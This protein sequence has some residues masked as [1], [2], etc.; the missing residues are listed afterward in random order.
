[1]RILFLITD[2][3]KG[4][5]ERYLI[6]LCSELRKYNDVE[7][8]IGSLYSGNQ[9]EDYTRDFKIVSLEY[10][11]FSFFRKN[12][13]VK[14]KELLD[15]FKP[16]VVHTHRF[17][18][19]FLSSYY[20]DRNIKYICHGHD[21]MEQLDNF[22]LS[23]LF[24]KRKILNTLEK[25]YLIKKKYNKVPTWVLANSK[26]TFDYYKKVMP[27]SVS[28]NVLLMYCGFNYSRFYFEKDYSK[29]NSSKIRMLNVSSF[30]DKKNQ[31][32]IVDIA[33]E[34]KKRNV[35]FE[36][37]LVGD[38]LNYRKVEK[39][40]VDNEVG[41]VVKMCGLQMYV[42]NLYHES[43]IYL[44]SAYYEP[45]GLVLLEAMASGLPVV[46]LDGKGNRDL[47]EQGKNGYMIY[48]QDPELFADRIIDIWNDKIK[49]REMSE[50]AQKFAKQYDM[51]NYVEQLLDLYRSNS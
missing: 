16:D 19:E 23:W 43:D 35:D 39:A 33:K 46:T 31:I 3:N 15:T 40:I 45:F 29:L 51:K 9:Y 5:A 13:C 11:T 10:S 30:A 17:L 18:A 21:N 44:H 4:G 47:I 8:I 20:V 24:D 32:F 38:G 28:K 48:D 12:E 7:F 22:R 41:D 26:D 49:Y 36:I 50:F 34:L 27:K 25:L 1:M 2:L 42:E 37:K 14:Y 6:D